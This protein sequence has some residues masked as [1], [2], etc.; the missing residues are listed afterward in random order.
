MVCAILQHQVRMDD[1]SQDLVQGRNSRSIFQSKD[2]IY[3]NS[4]AELTNEK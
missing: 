4:A 1:E 3:D 2:T